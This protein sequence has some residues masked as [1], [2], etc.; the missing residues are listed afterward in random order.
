MKVFYTR[1]L[2]RKEVLWGL[3]EGGMLGLE[4][5][6]GGVWDEKTGQLSFCFKASCPGIMES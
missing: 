5:G 1:L 6:K 3:V 2:L 4:G